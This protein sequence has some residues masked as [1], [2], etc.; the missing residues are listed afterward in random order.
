MPAMPGIR[1]DRLRER[2]Q[3][4]LWM[5]ELALQL[6]PAET[7]EQP[8]PADVQGVEQIQRVRDRHGRV[9]GQLSPP[10]LVVGLDRRAV[11]GKRSLEPDEAV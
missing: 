4:R 2:S 9:V 7:A 6:G 11:L 8:H 5:D 10:L 1:A 3:S